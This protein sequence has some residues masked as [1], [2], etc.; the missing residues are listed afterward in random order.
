M[1]RSNLEEE[2]SFLRGSIDDLEREHGAGD[3]SEPD[4]ERLRARYQSQADEVEQAL[5]SMASEAPVLADG[6]GRPV[7]A[8]ADG[9]VGVGRRRAVGNALAK[10]LARPRVRLVTGWGAF[11]CLAAAAAVLVMALTSTGPFGGPSPLP[12]DA[13][14]QIMLGEA[15][16]LGSKGDVT[17]ALATYDEVLALEPTEPVAL[18][19]AGWLARLAGIAE[20]EQTLV[21]NGD[22]EIEAAVRSAPGYALARAYDGVMLL[23]DRHEPGLAAAQFGAMLRDHPSA[24]LVRS[25]RAEARAAFR[26]AGEPAPAAIT[27]SGQ[28]AQAS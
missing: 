13:R 9:S 23:E 21:R 20:H 28:A 7:P 6:H 4:Y 26:A 8:E 25:V 19:N 5:A 1:S 12:V 10:A 22:A 24:G 14:V 3:V 15:G 17:E 2:L 18:A 27:D 16:I 11:A